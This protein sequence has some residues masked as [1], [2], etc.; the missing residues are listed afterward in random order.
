MC[1]NCKYICRAILASEATIYEDLQMKLQL[2]AVNVAVQCFS[3]KA[4]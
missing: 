3:F 4:Q 1:K 2:T